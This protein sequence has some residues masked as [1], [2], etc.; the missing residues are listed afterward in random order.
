M[1]GNSDNLRSGVDSVLGPVIDRLRKEAEAD[2]RIAKEDF[3][4]ELAEIRR[5]Q[6]AGFF[7][8]FG[9]FVVICAALVSGTWLS[10]DRMTRS[11]RERESGEA[12]RAERL[13]TLEEE[14]RARLDSLVTLERRM[15][16]ELLGRNEKTPP[17]REKADPGA[18]APEGQGAPE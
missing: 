10:L 18:P 13:G 12:S 7:T 16:V 3:S 11:A 9:I 17:E 1:S 5:K 4:R 6:Q 8:A 2:L 14:T 15:R